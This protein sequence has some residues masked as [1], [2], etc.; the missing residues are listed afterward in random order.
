MLTVVVISFPLLADGSGKAYF[1]D[2][3][4]R[5][6][7]LPNS[8]VSS[9]QQDSRGFLWFGTQSG[10]L[11]YDG[12]N[13]EKWSHDAFNS[14]T[15]PHELVQSLYI[16]EEDILWIGTYNGLSRFSPLDGTF[17][18]YSYETD[19]ENSISNSIVTAVAKD[20]HGRIWAAT[21]DGLNRLDSD[22]GEFTK[23]FHDEDDPASLADSVVR[24]LFTDS[25]GRLWVGSLGGL[26]LYDE[27]SDSFI[28]YNIFPSPYVMKITELD[29]DTL[30]VGTWGGGLSIFTISTGSFSHKSFADNSV[31]SIDVDSSGKIWVGTWGGGLFIYDRTDDSVVSFRSGTSDLALKSDTIYSLFRDDAGEMWVGTNG[32]GV[33]VLNPRK[34][35]YNFLSADNPEAP[36]IDQGKVNALLEDR[37]GY[38]W[39]SIY[40]KGINRFNP[41]NGNITRF[42]REAAA[43]NRR[44]EN[45][46]IADMM[47]DSKGNIWI[48]T[49]EGLNMWDPLK[50]E[51]HCINLKALLPGSSET[52]YFIFTAVYEDSEGIIWAGTHNS[53]LIRYDRQN[54]RI[55]LFSMDPHDENSISDNLIYDI[56][57]RQN[58]QFWIA[59]N[60]GLNLLDRNT[61]KI[62]RFLLDRENREGINSN[63]V[64]LLLETRNGEMWIGTGGG[65]INRYNEDGT[66][67]HI[68]T[69]EGL[70]DN[71]I[72]SL[73]EGESGKL[74][75]GTKYGLSIYDRES[76][77]IDIIGRDSGLKSPEIT[78]G[79]VRGSDNM[80]YFGAAD[81]VYRF[82][83]SLTDKENPIS[84]IHITSMEIGGE[85]YDQL[86]PYR[87]SG[88]IKLDY[89]DS[90]YISFDFVALNY[91]ESREISY[92]YKLEGFDREWRA[93]SARRYAIYTNIPPGSYSLK[94]KA[95][96][97]RREWKEMDIP[98]H[99]T[100][101]PPLWRQWWAYVLYALVI[102]AFLYLI[103]ALRTSHIRRQQ[104]MELKR[105][106]TY[107]SEILNSMPSLFVAI[108]DSGKITQW[109]RETEKHYGIKTEAALGRDILTIADDI[110]LSEKEI[111][112]C[113]R[114][115][116]IINKSRRTEGKDKGIR[117]ETIT[118][119]PI[120]SLGIRSAVIRIDDVTREVQLEEALVQS[121]KLLSIG[122][123]AAGMAHE[124]NNPLAGMIQN[125][126]V[127]QSRLLKSEGKKSHEEAA[128]KAGI[129]PK[130]IMIYMEERKIP[131]I[132]DSINTAGRRISDL[133][134]NIL[135]FARK[136]SSQFSEEDP[137]EIMDSVLTLAAADYNV[138]NSYDF[139]KIRIVK[140]YEE[141]L[142]PI[143]CERTNIQQV[144]LNLLKNGAQAMEPDLNRDPCFTIEI[145]RDQNE[146]NIVIS[147]EDN[148]K[149][150][151]ADVQ[152]RIFEPFFTTKQVGVG[153]GLGLSLSYFIITE[154]HKGKIKVDSSAG[155]GT[156][157]T[158]TLP[159]DRRK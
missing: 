48:T 49:N 72:M 113:I 16:D 56:L 40:N 98:L 47:E 22:S 134:K 28:H 80:L 118:I 92:T 135:S 29:S 153:T 89:N 88:D 114:K 85:K 148:G 151:D 86:S 70:S 14:N 156:R 91:L 38:F 65:G 61:E 97:D 115:G 102:L 12:Y 6:E 44:I 145:G 58:G 50:D 152:K 127:L 81:R 55:Q 53:G 146:E 39:I 122:G 2:T 73:V 68:T 93:P 52:E 126:S 84:R 130:Q 71:F 159:L 143:F 41:Q 20:R 57:E 140:T 23:Y 36:A 139:R 155:Q 142:P 103:V 96:M 112:Q 45:N 18:N 69:N 8:S 75:I 101:T 76:G 5:E 110:P 46:I 141:N 132:I 33:S 111:K 3:I 87:V 13:F 1:F 147:I 119:Y 74:W 128:Q 62:T 107:L 95:S 99:F 149:G 67:S 117:C 138:G 66:F 9:I 150:M 123:L 158:I 137:R 108:D 64:R 60:K 136:E 78:S 79:A 154:N 35:N 17:T 104:L 106:E 105:T 90:R 19:S 131:E 121:E 42:S 94:I 82:H 120:I 32:G 125:V 31:Y 116:E 63:N 24:S 26:D 109:N 51:M 7:G 157:F 15:L 83:S 59:T 54:D 25:S 43:E 4:S 144:L 37:E 34:Q 27:Q 133:V 129:S 77:K 21:L 124:I 11:R 100:I 30:L 10:L